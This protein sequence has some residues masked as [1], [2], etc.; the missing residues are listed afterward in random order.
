[1]KTP[2]LTKSYLF[3]ILLLAFAAAV[4]TVSAQSDSK[5]AILERIKAPTFPHKEIRITD[6]R[7]AS[8]GGKNWKPAFDKA[9]QQ[10][11]KNKGGR[12]IVPPGRY[13]IKGPIHFVSNTELHLQEGAVLV[14]SSDAK[15]Y[16]PVVRT[17]WEGT[18]VYNYSPFIY[19][20]QL[21]NVGITGKG[22]IKADQAKEWAAW[23][24]KQKPA[25]DLSRDMNHKGVPVEQRTFGEG[26]FLR[27]Q[28][29]QFFECENI[30]V[31]DVKIED[32]PFW[33]I[34][35]LLSKNITVRGV[36]F[37]AH[38]FNNDGIDPE[39]CQD[40]LIENIDFD[41]GDDNIAI[42]AG[43]DHEGRAMKRPSRDMVIR[44]CRFKG[45]HAVVIGSE[46][47]SGVYNIYVDDCTF[48]GYVK[49]GLYLKSNAD[50]GGEI[51]G[52]YVNNVQFGEVEDCIYIT[53][54]YK[55]EGQGNVTNIHDIR[56]N[57][58]SCQKATNKGIW[59][60]GF[61]GKKVHDLHIT[62]FRAD[63]ANVPVDIT[64]AEQVELSNIWF[65]PGEKQERKVG[66]VD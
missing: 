31:E 35:L 37:N 60:E 36:K 51:A 18:L 4:M 14:F 57:N 42:K 43:R 21:V 27:P 59:V 16:L 62:N 5:E 64:N 46:M 52:I 25:Q 66:K 9:M 2:F 22:T 65:G 38:N 33:C 3:I 28:L 34:H 12:I 55:N 6:F 23:R 54:N 44:N 26:K 40:V 49:R 30:L 58:V 45:L 63:S 20:Y 53:S 32:S 39:Y 19:G 24:A 7:S 48:A 47:S 15:A 29:I 61:A 17:S 10:S 8:S 11:R 1:M 56:F 41:N 50:R 13:F